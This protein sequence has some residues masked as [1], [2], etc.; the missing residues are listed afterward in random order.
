MTGEQRTSRS[1][2]EDDDGELVPVRMGAS[3]VEAERVAVVRFL[4]ALAGDEEAFDVCEAQLIV[5]IATRI[6]K[7]EHLELRV[8]SPKTSEAGAPVATSGQV[9]AAD[10]NGASASPAF[11][12][13]GWVRAEKGHARTR[14]G[15]S[16]KHPTTQDADG[17]EGSADARVRAALALDA[18]DL[19]VA[20]AG[21]I[22]AHAMRA[23][24]DE[25]AAEVVSRLAS[26]VVRRVKGDRER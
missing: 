8:S 4:N 13:D 3:D 7:G 24:H 16:E 12:P 17:Q 11:I 5:D 19:G 25:D 2:V 18:I 26:S 1:E 15:D 10:S 14:E 9:P 23:A 21:F 22:L 20:R 6:A